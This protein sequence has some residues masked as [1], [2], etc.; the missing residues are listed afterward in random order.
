M[1]FR[2]HLRADKVY[3]IGDVEAKMVDDLHKQVR[4]FEQKSKTKKVEDR[5]PWPKELHVVLATT[6]GNVAYGRAVYD[7]LRML[8]RRTKLSLVVNGLSMSMGSS[9]MMAVP[10][11]RRFIS[12]NGQI[13]V[14][15]V[16][17]ETPALP[18]L[19][20]SVRRFVYNEWLVSLEQAEKM[21]EWTI[22]TIAK[23]SGNSVEQ[24]R[25]WYETGTYFDADEAIEHGFVTDK[26]R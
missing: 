11:E 2:E 17:R 1:R 12:Q 13:M 20:V 10:L 21:N 3:L 6:G 23:G 18:S 8:G 26:L 4:D 9:I 24:V 22:K 16:R 15:E 14:H 25:E 5:I 19:P 7:V